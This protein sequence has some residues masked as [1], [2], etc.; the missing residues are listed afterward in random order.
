MARGAIR[1]VPVTSPVELPPAAFLQLGDADP[2]GGQLAR[3][4]QQG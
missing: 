3:R 1:D 2:G 4:I